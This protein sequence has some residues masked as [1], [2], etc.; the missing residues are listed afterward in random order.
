MDQKHA[1]QYVILHRICQTIFAILCII[2]EY[3]QRIK[4]EQP[5]RR[6]KIHVFDMGCGK[7]KKIVIRFSHLLNG[8]L[9]IVLGGDQLKWKMGG[10]DSV[11]FAGQLKNEF[12]CCLRI[13][14]LSC[15]SCWKLSCCMRRTLSFEKRQL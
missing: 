2:A 7:G 14:L 6:N 15:R 13:F 8:I 4:K 9:W 10:V 5:E 3:L 1:D 11:T 12:H